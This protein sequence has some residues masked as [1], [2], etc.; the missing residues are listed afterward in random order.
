MS[1][2]TLEALH[3]AVVGGEHALAGECIGVADV[4]DDV[5]AVGLLHG[6]VVVDPQAETV[7]NGLVIGNEQGF[8]I[9]AEFHG[10][11]EGLDLVFFPVKR[12][13]V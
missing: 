5:R 13:L 3:K 12:N 10:K 8:L 2:V 9:A 4:E 1:V 7:R 11:F 6:A